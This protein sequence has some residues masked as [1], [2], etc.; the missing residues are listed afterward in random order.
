MFLLSFPTTNEYITPGELAY[1]KEYIENGRINTLVAISGGGDI[2]MVYSFLVIA[3]TP[4]ENVNI[5]FVDKDPSQCLHS[6]YLFF[7]FFEA[8]DKE[9]QRYREE[10][11]RYLIDGIEDEIWAGTRKVLEI[12]TECLS[13]GYSSGEKPPQK[14]VGMLLKRYK[15]MEGEDKK[16]LKEAVMRAREREKDITVHFKCSD[17]KEALKSSPPKE[18]TILYLSN[19]C[20]IRGPCFSIPGWVDQEKYCRE[21][22]RYLEDGS[23]ISIH[24]A[25]Y[26]TAVLF[27]IDRKCAF[28]AYSFPPQLY[29][30]KDVTFGSEW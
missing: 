2:A 16:I 17:I 24:K 30:K 28:P 12:Y 14:L 26:K 20:G 22:L 29:T 1:L 11:E 5:T 9:V 23:L 21:M 4:K 19:V 7:S 10:V 18:A 27:Y 6:K 15:E 8:S 25:F 3:F 13:Y